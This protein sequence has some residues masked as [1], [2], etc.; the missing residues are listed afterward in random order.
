VITLRCHLCE[1]SVAKYFP[2]ESARRRLA[3]SRVS[4][5]R[6][7]GNLSSK[8]LTGYLGGDMAFAPSKN[9]EVNHGNQSR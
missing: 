8:P 4:R 7:H 3:H 9:S 2:C 5:E 6:V 1:L